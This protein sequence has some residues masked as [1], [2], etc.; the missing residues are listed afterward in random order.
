MLQ[1]GEQRAMGTVRQRDKQS[2]HLS[3]I[4]ATEKNFFG[5]MGHAKRNSYIR[6]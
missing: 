2:T 5:L 1:A 3:Q 6:S 4:E